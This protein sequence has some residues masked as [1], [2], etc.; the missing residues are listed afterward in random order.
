MALI[1]DP[2]RVTVCQRE[3]GTRYYDVRV[4][5]KTKPMISWQGILE[6]PAPHQ[7]VAVLAGALAEELCEKYG[8]SKLDP[9]ECARR[10]LELAKWAEKQPVKPG[11]EPP[12]SM[13]RALL[14]P[15]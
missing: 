3:D 8:D 13:D 4:R 12:R 15:R 9:S 6:Y 2:V 11:G 10:A 1:L 5:S 14:L 7:K